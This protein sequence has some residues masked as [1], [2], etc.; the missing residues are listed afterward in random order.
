MTS[1][2][3]HSLRISCCIVLASLFFPLSFSLFLV[4][5]GFSFSPPP[6]HPVDLHQSSSSEEQQVLRWSGMFL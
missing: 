2:F 3:N 6:P 1:L 5:P 4:P